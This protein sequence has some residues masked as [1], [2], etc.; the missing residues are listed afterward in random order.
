ME[1]RSRLAKKRDLAV[2]TSF[3]SGA[4]L[5]SASFL[6]ERSQQTSSP[7]VFVLF[8][9]IVF[10][11]VLICRE[12]RKWDRF[13][14]I[15][16]SE[17]LDTLLARLRRFG[18]E[19]DC[20]DRLP[21]VRS[22]IGD[23]NAIADMLLDD[24]GLH[25]SRTTTLKDTIHYANLL[26]CCKNFRRYL[27]AVR[28]MSRTRRFRERREMKKRL[29]ERP[30]D[31]RHVPVTWQLRGWEKALVRFL[32]ISF[33]GMYVLVLLVAALVVFRDLVIPWLTGP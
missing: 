32:M 16:A 10:L 8:S 11:Y 30:I 7:Y 14:E 26:A 24:L 19:D 29:T 21:N 23:Y 5:A 27:D 9:L 25:Y 18:D 3:A 2:Y 4:L 1:I 28:L 33:I 20:D 6:L 17:E 31:N 12:K 22:A 13:H 15:V